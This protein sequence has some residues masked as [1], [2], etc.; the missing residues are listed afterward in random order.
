MLHKEN[1]YYIGDE[2]FKGE[3]E[4]YKRVENKIILIFHGEMLY[5]FHP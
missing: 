5:I 2:I 1:H 4:D 3:M